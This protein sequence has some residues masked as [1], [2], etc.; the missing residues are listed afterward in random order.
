LNSFPDR[1]FVTAIGT[2]SG[3]TLT[4]AVLVNHL[5]AAYWK[6][7]Q[8]G[9][10]TDSSWMASML[11][12]TVIIPERYCLKIPAS[13]HFAAENEGITISLEDFSLPDVQGLLVVEGA[14]GL[15]VP[16]NG[17]EVLADLISALRLPVILVIN[18]YLGA[19]NHSLLSIAELER[20][21]IPVAGLVF[22]G[23]DFQN[24]E[25]IILARCP[26]P[27]I[28]RIPKLDEVNPN[29]IEELSNKV[30]LNG[31]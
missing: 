1:I 27:C 10:P 13:P 25:S 5:R 30:N 7:V 16:L 15:M 23:T 2:D 11:P 29:A 14:G 9:S 19:L 4:S 8:C 6:P 17:K 21:N 12:E 31:L 28:L 18:H 3:K 20:R 22:N 26:A 24:A